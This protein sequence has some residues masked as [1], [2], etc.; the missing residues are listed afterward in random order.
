[1]A[2]H[3]K[4]PPPPL[5]QTLRTLRAATGFHC[6]FV[7]DIF[8]LPF[9][10]MHSS[11]V[12]LVKLSTGMR[13]ASVRKHKPT[14]TS[15]DTS[16]ACWRLSATLA[17]KLQ[18]EQKQL[19]DVDVDVDRLVTDAEA[20]AMSRCRKHKVHSAVRLPCSSHQY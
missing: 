15:S 10:A 14:Y 7:S 18:Q 1:M 8:G 17:Q 2:W 12:K 4:E 16:W 13:T 6:K 9:L 20:L 5:P 3:T 11:Q 19:N